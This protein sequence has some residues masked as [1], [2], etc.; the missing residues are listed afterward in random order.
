MHV[1]QETAAAPRRPVPAGAEQRAADR[2]DFSIEV[3][4]EAG[5]QF[6]TGFTENISAG[7][8]FIATY[9]ALPLGAN[10]RVAFR[11]PGVDRV[12][13]CETEVR[14]VREP[15][16]RSSLMPGMGVRFLDLPPDDVRLLDQVIKRLETLF[17][18]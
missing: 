1:A 5:H 17:Y 18:E 6:F 4:G 14:W 2:I 9:Q 11:I 16:D 7:G 3:S 12:F 13:E 15:D 10:L 8:L